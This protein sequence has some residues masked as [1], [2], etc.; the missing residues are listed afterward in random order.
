MLPLFHVARPIRMH[1]KVIAPAK[2]TDRFSL[3][4]RG[5]HTRIGICSSRTVRHVFPRSLQLMH[6]GV[7]YHVTWCS[8]L[9]LHD[10]AWCG[11]M[12]RDV[13]DVSCV[14]NS[15]VQPQK[16]IRDNTSS[17]ERSFFQ[18][19][20][21]W[22]GS[23]SY[24]RFGDRHGTRSL[25]SKT[26]CLTLQSL[27][28]GQLVEGPRQERKQ[29]TLHTATWSSISSN[30]MCSMF[31]RTFA[32][33]LKQSW[34]TGFASDIAKNSHLVA[35]QNCSYHFPT[36]MIHDPQVHIVQ[37]FHTFVKSELPAGEAKGGS[38]HLGRC[39]RPNPVCQ[40]SMQS[41]DVKTRHI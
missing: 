33:H 20:T 1:P 8:I 25:Y 3:G 40:A 38:L 15:Y 13:H 34:H 41:A 22:A 30:Y 32:L 23:P 10:V 5:N 6:P 14:T 11:V 35:T 21:L 16:T 19:S 28:L 9:M 2:S 7:P 4:Y 37:R 18:V 27:A 39:I 12:M 24:Q 36:E 31:V 29:I 17:N 26:L